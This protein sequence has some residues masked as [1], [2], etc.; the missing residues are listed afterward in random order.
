[1]PQA[2]Y[3]QRE[4][5]PLPSPPEPCTILAKSRTHEKTYESG[6]PAPTRQIGLV[7]CRS[8]QH[9]VGLFCIQTVSGT[10]RVRASHRYPGAHAPIRGLSATTSGKR[11][12]P[13]VKVAAKVN[14]GWGW[15]SRGSGP[16]PRLHRQIFAHGTRPLCFG[17]YLNLSLVYKDIEINDS[18]DGCHCGTCL[19]FIVPFLSYPM[20][21]R[22]DPLAICSDVILYYIILYYI[23]LYCIIW[24]PISIYFNLQTEHRRS[25]PYAPDNYL[26]L[27]AI[28]I[29]I[30]DK[31]TLPFPL[32]SFYIHR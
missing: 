28:S 6:E 15:G 29:F 7:N 27:C 11:D 2:S 9:Q 16:L 17:L 23:I 20:L 30:Y 5:F 12:A 13:S 14:S 19:F 21:F 24:P 22:A 4:T 18:G 10:N 1:M 8:K 31:D 26:S 32:R 25:L 3:W